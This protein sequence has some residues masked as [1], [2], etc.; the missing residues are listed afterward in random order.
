MEGGGA[1][2]HD[3]CWCVS[4]GCCCWEWRVR[5]WGGGG[6][7]RCN[8]SLLTPTL[9]CKL[10]VLLL[11]GEMW[12]EGAR[13]R[14][15]VQFKFPRSRRWCVS[16]WCCCREWRCEGRGEMGDAFRVCSW[17]TGV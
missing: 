2:A 6:V 9:V 13:V 7:R 11:G 15:M 14:W 8:Y 12:G 10:L 16:G 3:R 1:L 5:G 4:C 17:L